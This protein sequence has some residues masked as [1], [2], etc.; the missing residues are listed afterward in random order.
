MARAAL[1]WNASQL[2]AAAGVGVATVN[3]FERGGV[4][5]TEETVTK[6]RVALEEAGVEFIPAGPYQGDGGAGARLRTRSGG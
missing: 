5:T 6:L 1:E 2:A 4:V 3:R